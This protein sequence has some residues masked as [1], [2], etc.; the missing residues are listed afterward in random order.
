MS[1][2]ARRLGI[3]NSV[4]TK[5]LNE[6]EEW[7]G[8]KLIFRSTRSL[9]LSQ[10]G[11]TYYEQI[12]SII[13]KVDELEKIRDEDTQLLSGE[14]KITAPVIIGKKLLCPLLSKFHQIHPGI[15][16]KV[17]LNNAFN[18]MVDE[19]IDMAL[20]ISRMPD[21]NFIARRLCQIRLA[22]FASPEYITRFGAP[23]IPE[24][25]KNHSCL[26]D[27]S[28]TQA[29]R[30]SFVNLQGDNQSVSVNGP[31]DINDAESVIDLCREGIGIAQLPEFFIRDSLQDG[32]L[33]E[34]LLEY[35]VSD[36][37]ISLQYH[38]KGLTN[39]SSKAF[40]EFV[41]KELNEAT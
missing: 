36:L 41:V 29:R 40:Y 21:S 17:I 37:Y 23:L 13:S 32:S 24:D 1:A 2:A 3:A 16:I 8:R 35:S 20:R 22:L 34:L 5:N 30:W 38:Q 11:T 7:L 28:V 18:D 12:K 31:F 6:L 4:V 19:G 27:G 15:K 33:V 25:L 39:P 9:Q 10:E 14:I 26:I